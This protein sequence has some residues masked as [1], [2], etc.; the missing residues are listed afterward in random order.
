MPV[1]YLESPPKCIPIDVDRQ[2][3]IDDFLIETI[4]II[5]RFHQPLKSPLNPILSP[6]TRSHENRNTQQKWHPYKTL[7]SRSLCAHIYQYNISMYKME[8][9]R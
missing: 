3:F 9:H 5:R 1:R 2:L 6:E 7:Y 4:T 8:K